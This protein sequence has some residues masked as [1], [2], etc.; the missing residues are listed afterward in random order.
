MSNQE[1]ASY[2]EIIRT[3]KLPPRYPG[4]DPR[5]D[6]RAL[7][8]AYQMAGADYETALAM[9]KADMK[10]LGVKLPKCS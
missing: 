4:R 8:L 7:C 6:L 9:A 10:N 5:N 3:F 1:K 2:A